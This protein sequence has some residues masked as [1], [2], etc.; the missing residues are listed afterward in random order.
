MKK[1]VW[2]F[3][4]STSLVAS[5]CEKNN[6]PSPVSEI[7][8]DLPRTT[9]PAE[10]QGNWMY[11][12]FSLTEYWSQN[13]A[14][15][16]GNALEFAIA[17]RFNADGTY[18]QYFTAS[19][20]VGGVRTYQQSVTKGTVEVNAGSKTIKT[21]PATAHYRRT[22]NGQTVEERD[23]SKSELTGTTTYIYSTA[24]EPNGTKAILMQIQG[25]NNPLAFIKK[26]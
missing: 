4:I 13:P 16:L 1:I 9:V 21:H 18:V 26:Q 3:V 22:R 10:L 12:N 19:S 11:G 24:S 14:D 20:V 2:L 25:S 5:A 15:Y 17:F 23:L 8:A 6:L 7:P